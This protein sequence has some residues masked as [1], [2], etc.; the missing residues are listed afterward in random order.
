M[1]TRQREKPHFKI[2][3][4]Q[5]ATHWT[6]PTTV[7]RRA[8]RTRPLFRVTPEENRRWRAPSV[9]GLR[10]R[11]P[12]RR[13]AITLAQR[14]QR[15]RL[16]WVGAG[17]VVVAAMLVGVF[18]YNTPVSSQPVLSTTASGSA[19]TLATDTQTLHFHTPSPLGALPLHT[20][21]NASQPPAIQAQAAF[22]YDPA[23]GW[24]LYQKNPDKPMP[25]ASLTKIMTLLLATGSGSLDQRVTIGPDAAALVNSNNS[26]MDL[27]AGEQVTMRQLLYGLMLP[28]G[29]DAALAIADAVAGDSPTFVALMNTHAQQLGLGHTSFVSPD[30]VSDANIS[31]ARDMAEISAIAIMQPD[32]AQI[33]S[34]RNQVFVQTPAHKL[35]TLWNTNDLLPGAASPYPGVNGIKTG[36]TSSAG[37]CMAFSAVVNGH[38]IVGVILGDPSEQARVSDAHALLDYGFA[39]E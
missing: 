7:D 32:V 26:Y 25:V 35:Y 16:V 19:D 8:R 28:G 4:P 21:A 37:Y 34:T 17:A 14:R 3:A 5:P 6:A 13:T 10:A 31:T 24:L 18:A 27:S 1:V 12:F 9:K 15:R 2:E 30:G 33:T 29:N 22:V 20:G 38:L 36:Y 23:H 39:Q 11:W